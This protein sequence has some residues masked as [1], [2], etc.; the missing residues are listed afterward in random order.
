MISAAQAAPADLNTLVVNKVAAAKFRSEGDIRLPL[1]LVCTGAANGSAVCPT[2]TKSGRPRVFTP[3]VFFSELG[4]NPRRV[5]ICAW[6]CPG[7][8]EQLRGRFGHPL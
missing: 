7:L 2:R 5:S 8:G 6:I 3:G 4:R 1:G